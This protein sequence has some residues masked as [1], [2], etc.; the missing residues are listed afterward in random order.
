MKPSAVTG[1][2]MF[3]GALNAYQALPAARALPPFTTIVSRLFTGPGSCS[4]NATAA[5]NGHRRLA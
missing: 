2:A 3:G 5:A 1:K 4:C